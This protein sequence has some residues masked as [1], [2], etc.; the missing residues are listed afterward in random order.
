MLGST[1]DDIAMTNPD[2]CLRASGSAPVEARHG[3]TLLAHIVPDALPRTAMDAFEPRAIE[4]VEGGAAPLLGVADRPITFDD[5]AHRAWPT[6]R[7]SSGSG[8]RPACAVCVSRPHR[9]R[10]PCAQKDGP[11]LCTGVGI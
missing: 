2:L 1:A 11:L 4:Q 9:R 6:P 7:R 5:I 3:D 8:A 10:P